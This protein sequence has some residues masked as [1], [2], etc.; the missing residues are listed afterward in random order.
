MSAVSSRNV[1]RG[2][3]DIRWIRHAC[4]QELVHFGLSVTNANI[5]ELR[6]MPGD[7][8]RYFESLKQKA[9]SGATNNARRAPAWMQTPCMMPDFNPP[10]SSHAYC[11]HCEPI[12]PSAACCHSAAACSSSVHVLAA[13]GECACCRNVSTALS[14]S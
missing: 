1:W 9:I 12:K 8:N 5:S 3:T 14:T 11:P 4:T 2:C 10:V 7:D 6:D 13:S